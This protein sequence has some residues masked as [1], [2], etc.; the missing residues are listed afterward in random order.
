[1]IKVDEVLNAKMGANNAGAETVKDYLKCLLKTLWGEGE[2]F[3]GKRPFGNSG[4]EY[5]LYSALV[6]NGLCAGEV[7]EDGCFEWADKDVAN[8]LIFSAIEAL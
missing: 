6:V 1:M 5:E 2:G 4:W 7:D 8:K 3:S